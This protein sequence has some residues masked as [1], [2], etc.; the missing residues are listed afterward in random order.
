MIQ[1]IEFLIK[2]YNKKYEG[3][4]A[5]YF[6]VDNM[7]YFALKHLE[8]SLEQNPEL[9]LKEFLTTTRIMKNCME[10]STS[11]GLKVVEGFTCRDAREDEYK[12]EL[13]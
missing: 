2:R 9:T 4:G 3:L 1:I 6:W 8:S 13:S 11:N 7:N 12:I 10:K 5:G